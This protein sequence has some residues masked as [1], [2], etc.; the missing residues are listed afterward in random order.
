MKEVLSANKTKVEFIQSIHHWL[1]LTLE[2]NGKEEYKDCFTI[3]GSSIMCNLPVNYFS[4]FDIPTNTK[5]EMK[6]ITKKS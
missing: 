1:M 6:F 5:I 2:R 3:D 4:N